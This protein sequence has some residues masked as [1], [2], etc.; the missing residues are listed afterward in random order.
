MGGA[1]TG[2]ATQIKSI[3]PKFLFTHC[4]GNALNLAVGDVFKNVPQLREAL[5]TAYEI[6]KLIKKSPKRN[7][8]IDELR[9]KTKNDSKSIHALC[10]LDGLYVGK[11]WHPYR[12]IMQN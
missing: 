12:I 4:Y 6:C 11:V 3:N 5:E 2:V 10:P 1:K 8:K 9:N 7:T